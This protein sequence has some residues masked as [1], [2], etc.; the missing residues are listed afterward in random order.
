[1]PKP[2]LTIHLQPHSLSDERSI[3]YRIL[4]YFIAAFFIVVVAISG[5]FILAKDALPTSSLY[6][7]KR[8]SEKVLVKLLSFQPKLSL[9]VEFIL[10]DQ[11]IFEFEKIST[12]SKDLS[13]AR[14]IIEESIKIENQVTLL[15]NKTDRLHYYEGLE[16]MLTRLDMLLTTYRSSLLNETQ[17]IQSPLESIAKIDLLK[18]Q[19]SELQSKITNDKHLQ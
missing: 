5:L 6:S 14:T 11:R 7:V 3:I 2:Q 17:N 18:S 9:N 13:F 4:T 19:I 1:M 15:P 10:L 12:A 16:T 8:T